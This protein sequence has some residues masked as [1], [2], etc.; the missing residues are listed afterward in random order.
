[1]YQSKEMKKLIIVTLTNIFDRF[2]LY[3]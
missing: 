3:R 2:N 1:M